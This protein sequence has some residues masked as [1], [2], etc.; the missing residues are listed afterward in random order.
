MNW[1][2]RLAM[3]A[4]CAL[5]ACASLPTLD[6]PRV[7]LADIDSVSFEGMELRMRVKLR[8]QNP[9]RIAL[10]YD[11]IDVQV[12][13]Q[14]RGVARGVSDERGSVPGYGEAIVALPV[15][16]SLMDLGRQA[17]H[18]LQGGGGPV[19]YTIEGKLGGTLLGATRFHSEGQLALPAPGSGTDEGAG[20]EREGNPL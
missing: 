5:A 15:T 6:P 4:A 18:I 14:G 3:V 13:L 12:S 8:V 17:L 7:T 19:H 2:R 1:I 10:D 9:N 20:R 16:I 11:G